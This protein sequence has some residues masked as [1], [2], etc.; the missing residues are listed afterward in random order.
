MNP[1]YQIYQTPTVL[2]IRILLAAILLITTQSAT[3]ATVAG[4]VVFATG[5]PQASDAGGAI[6]ALK[7]K[8]DVYAGD[9]LV[10]DTRSRLQV[11]F[12][13]GAYVSVQ[14]GTEYKIDE[15]RYSGKPD[16]N[17][18]AVYSLL[19]GGIRAVTGLIGKENHD[20][21][22]VNTSVATIGIRGTGHNT[23]I[24]QGDCPGKADGLYHNTWEGVTYVEND[25]AVVDVP[26]GK[27]VYVKN[28]N[29]PI[30]FL[31]QPSAVTAVETGKQRQQEDKDAQER[32]EVFVAGDQ[33]TATGDQTVIVGES[34][35]TPVPSKVLTNQ[36]FIAVSPD[37]LSPGLVDVTAGFDGSLFFNDAGDLIGAL[38]T[39]DNDLGGL[40]RTFGT[41]DINSLLGGDDPAAVSEIQALLATADQNLIDQ[42]K[43]NP[44]KVAEFELTPGGIGWG[45]FSNGSLISV[46]DGGDTELDELSG[47]QSIHFVFGP[48]PSSIPTV[49]SAVYN[50]VGGTQSTS[51]SGATIGQG[52]TG[53][54]L[55]VDFG[56]SSATLSMDVNH[57]GNLYFVSG[58]LLINAADNEIFDLTNGVFASTNTIGSACNPDCMVHI[59]G[60]FA[61]APD[62]NGFPLHA[63][64]EYDIQESDIIIGVAGFTI[65]PPP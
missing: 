22:K 15:Y 20:A 26:T 50:F 63:G 52:A 38:F 39:E 5:N 44:A 28:L 12:V 2:L 13:D 60:G 6:R 61:G 34:R 35:I 65:P 14:P 55:T 24:C 18:K 4:R 49:G 58:D 59:D 7:R 31:S 33:R 27:G 8:D 41:V 62:P 25:V 47:F 46:D 29:S 56:T 21:Y 11:S 45:R 17:E 16:G 9:T 19:K 32:Q 48:T 30:Q 23:R 57:A 51:V 40:E 36:V 10:T 1:S 37:Q 54:M 53:G 42:F 3:A 43:Q 64:I